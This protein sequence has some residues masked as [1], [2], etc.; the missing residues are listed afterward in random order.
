[1]TTEEIVAVGWLG[2][3]LLCYKAMP[4]RYVMGMEF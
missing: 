1:M 2:F 3:I 4:Q